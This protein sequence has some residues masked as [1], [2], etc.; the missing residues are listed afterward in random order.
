MAKIEVFGEAPNQFNKLH[1]PDSEIESLVNV[2]SADDSYPESIVFQR[3]LVKNSTFGTKNAETCKYSSIFGLTSGE[4]ASPLPLQNDGVDGER[5]W[6]S[7]QRIPA[8]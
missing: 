1:S 2:S 5:L 4:L 6:P 8:P 7:N 3:K